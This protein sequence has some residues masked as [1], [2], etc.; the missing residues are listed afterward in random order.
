MVCINSAKINPNN[1]Y[2]KRDK[3]CHD[4]S[5][6]ISP[7][8]ATDYEVEWHVM[9]PEIA[10]INPSGY[11]LGLSPGKT[12]IYAMIIDCSGRR[13]KSSIA[14]V[15]V[16]DYTDVTIDDM[17][18]ASRVMGV[19][20]TITLEAVVTPERAATKGVIWCSTDPEVLSISQNGNELTV[21]ALKLGNAVVVATPVDDMDISSCCTINV[22]AHVSVG[23]V[24]IS[25]KA[26]TLDIGDYFKLGKTIFPT[27]ASDRRVTWHSDKPSFVS[28]NDEG[29]VRALK[30]GTAT[31]TVRTQDGN[32][33]D[34]CVITVIDPAKKVIVRRENDAYFEV[35]FPPES[36]DEDINNDTLKDA[37]VWKSIGCDLSLEENQSGYPLMQ[38]S[39][40]Y[41]YNESEIRYLSN[42]AYHYNI[43]QLA[44]LYRF[45]PL[46][47]EYYMRHDACKGMDLV[48]RLKFED[49][50][51]LEI[52]GYKPGWFKFRIEN[53][54]PVYSEDIGGSRETYYTNAEIIFGFHNHFDWVGFHKDILLAIFKQ[55]P[56]MSQI[57]YAVKL[58]QALFFSGSV[59]GSCSSLASEFTF[60]YADG[61]VKEEIKDSLTDGIEDN[62]KVDQLKTGFKHFSWTV[63]LLATLAHTVIDNFIVPNY[64]DIAIYDSIRRQSNYSVVCMKGDDE[65]SMQDFITYNDANQ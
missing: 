3:W 52:F 17:Y 38:G 4:V 45:D 10:S 21:T 32:Y 50:V 26:K 55:I 22:L 12:R 60:G 5:L 64:N 42:L 58:Y 25:K 15:T 61:Q 24:T 39:T 57:D 53:G 51:Y 19:G 8:N 43:K 28:V 7:A 54:S 6:V 37:R 14:E 36:D 27:T 56:G 16:D 40:D 9:D 46:G 35:Q 48:D 65:I 2:T 31:V 33:T 44:L 49:D 11:V 34:S 1:I 59:L 20:D 13:I 41:E 23:G 30:E 63:N 18:T 29:E 47:V 62:A